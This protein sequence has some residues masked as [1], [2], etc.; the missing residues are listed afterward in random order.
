MKI[1]KTCK[2]VYFI[3]DNVVDAIIM[4]TPLDEL[5]MLL[6]GGNNMFMTGLYFRFDINLGSKTGETYCASIWDWEGDRSTTD[7]KKCYANIPGLAIRN[8]IR[9][10]VMEYIPGLEISN[11]IKDSV[12]QKKW[13][14]LKYIKNTLE[15]FKHYV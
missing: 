5:M 11:Y 15:S 1:V 12:D 6:P 8:L 13:D 10:F 9:W 2:E 3:N 4:N 7:Y 14:D